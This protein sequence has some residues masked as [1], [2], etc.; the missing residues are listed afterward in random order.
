MILRLIRLVIRPGNSLMHPDELFANLFE[1][2][3]TRKKRNLEIIQAVCRE[4]FERGSKDYSVATI[5]RLSVERGGPAKSTIHNKTGCDFQTLIKAW[6]SHTGGALKKPAKRTSGF[7]YS[8][9]L[10][11]IPDPAI[12]SIVGAALAEN[13]K[14]RRELAV[15]KSNTEFVVDRR[16]KAITLS[17]GVEAQ[18][19][20]VIPAS[21]GLSDVEKEALAH[22]ISDQHLEDEGW[23]ADE[24]GRVVS[25]RTK[26]AVF[27]VGFIAA[28]RK[29]LQDG[30]C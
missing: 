13:T 1:N 9:L 17:A 22:A 29:V 30:G 18:V 21:F 15:L 10:S 4:Q 28:L 8:E 27:K 24:Y 23:E 11:K 25:T 5:S 20:Q 16:T 19:A 12:R 14:L 2:A 26:R 6:A 3:G 7:D